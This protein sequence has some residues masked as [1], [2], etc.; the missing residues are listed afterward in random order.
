MENNDIIAWW[1]LKWLNKLRK[2]G[3]KCL[4]WL[5]IFSFLSRAQG[6]RFPAELC[7]IQ[8]WKRKS[9]VTEEGY[10]YTCIAKL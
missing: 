6:S 7:L 4:D 10:T 8:K 2:C 5:A 1:G 3:Q 9:Q